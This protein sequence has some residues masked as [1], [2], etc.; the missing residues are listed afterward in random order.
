MELSMRIVVVLAVICSTAYCGGCWAAYPRHPEPWGYLLDQPPEEITTWT[1]RQTDDDR[2]VDGRNALITQLI[3]KQWNAKVHAA[4]GDGLVEVQRK[5][6]AGWPGYTG[7]GRYTVGSE[8][9]SELSETNRVRMLK[10]R[11]GD[12]FE[13]LARKSRKAENPTLARQTYER[14]RPQKPEDEHLATWQ[15]YGEQYG[16]L[17]GND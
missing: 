8:G 3:G 1:L 14:I 6:L 5:L 2:I 9:L 16:L 10:G 12:T 17:R 11:A 15:H 4:A 7:V 13:R